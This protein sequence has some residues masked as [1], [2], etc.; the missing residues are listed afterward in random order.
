MRELKQIILSL[1]EGRKINKLKQSLRLFIEEAKTLGLSNQYLE[2]A[3]E[4]LEFFEYE[5]CFD[6]IITQIY[7][8]NIEIDNEF[9]IEICKIGEMLKLPIENYSFIKGCIR[10]K[11]SS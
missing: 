8:S 11:H 10:E 6:T 1:I 2:E 5:L 3:I 9:F 7:E 4:F